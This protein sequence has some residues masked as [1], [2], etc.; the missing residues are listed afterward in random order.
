MRITNKYDRNVTSSGG[1]VSN[2]AN[3]REKYD[4]STGIIENTN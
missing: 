1:K 4:I 3:I 2:V